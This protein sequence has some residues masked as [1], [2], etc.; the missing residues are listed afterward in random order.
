M[1]GMNAAFERTHHH[2]WVRNGWVRTLVVLTL[3]LTVLGG[4]ALAQSLAELAE[5]EKKRRS[6]VKGTAK[7]IS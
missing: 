6:D 3:S 5:K 1:K 2:H 7:V 4:S